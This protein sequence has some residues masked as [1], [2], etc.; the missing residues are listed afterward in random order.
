MATNCGNQKLRNQICNWSVQVNTSV[1]FFFFVSSTSLLLKI[2]EMTRIYQ[3][4]GLFRTDIEVKSMVK[5]QLQNKLIFYE[6]TFMFIRS[7]VSQVLCVCLIAKWN[8][9]MQWCGCFPG[10]KTSLT[11]W[12]MEYKRQRRRCSCLVWCEA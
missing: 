5:E 4:V 8:E 1:N 9:Y 10:G 7:S 6:G 2:A 12:N 11:E 3:F